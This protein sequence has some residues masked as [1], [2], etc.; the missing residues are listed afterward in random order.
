MSIQRHASESSRSNTGRARD[1][2]L[3]PRLAWWVG[4]ARAFVLRLL[5]CVFDFM[6]FL[7][8]LILATLGGEGSSMQSTTFGIQGNWHARAIKPK[9]LPQIEC[10]SADS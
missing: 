4:Q 9:I 5:E 2:A 7:L 6:I 1:F 10:P 8:A 3:K